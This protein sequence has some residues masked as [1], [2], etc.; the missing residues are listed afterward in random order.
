M[1]HLSIRLRRSCHVKSGKY[2]HWSSEWSMVIP[3]MMQQ[4]HTGE[5]ISEACLKRRCRRYV[6]RE[7]GGQRKFGQL[8]TASISHGDGNATGSS[9][10]GASINIIWAGNSTGGA[11][12]TSMTSWIISGGLLILHYDFASMM[13]G[14][15]NINGCSTAKI[16]AQ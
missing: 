16:V 8:P 13:S 14:N 10:I 9:N 12:S 3:N 4:R 1:F 2:G 5:A 11:A 15:S 7:A 6:C